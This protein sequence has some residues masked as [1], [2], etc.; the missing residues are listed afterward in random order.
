MTVRAEDYEHRLIPKGS[1][2]DIPCRLIEFYPSLKSSHSL[3]SVVPWSLPTRFRTTEVYR[4]GHH[5]PQQLVSRC[6]VMLRTDR[7]TSW[8][9]PIAKEKE[10]KLEENGYENNGT[11]TFRKSR[12]TRCFYTIVYLKRSLI[13]SDLFCSVYKSHPLL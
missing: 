9:N 5:G 6:T 11:L 8:W 13:S 12:R 10:T 2:M 4:S 7:I 1:Q 3:S